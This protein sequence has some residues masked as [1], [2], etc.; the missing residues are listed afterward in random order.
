MICKS[1]FAVVQGTISLSNGSGN[2]T[3]N[4]PNGFNKDNCVVLTVAI[5]IY[6][7]KIFSYNSAS[8]MIFEGRLT[9]NNISVRC[10]AIDGVGTSTTKN[11]KVILMKI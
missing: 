10:T 1:E 11:C 2:T 5:N 8:Q 3:L 4:Y 7:E 6:G 9:D